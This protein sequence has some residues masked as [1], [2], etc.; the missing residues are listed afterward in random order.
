M[1][2]NLGMKNKY[3]FNFDLKHKRL[4]K[5]SISLGIDY[6]ICCSNFLKKEKG[7]KFL[8]DTTDHKKRSMRGKWNYGYNWEKKVIEKSEIIME[9]HIEKESSVLL[10]YVN[11]N[12]KDHFFILH[13]D[14]DAYWHEMP[15]LGF[16]KYV[17]TFKHKI[18]SFNCNSGKINFFSDKYI[19]DEFKN[20]KLVY[21]FKVNK[22]KYSF[23]SMNI[24]NESFKKDY[25]Y[26]NTVGALLVKD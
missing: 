4:K 19:E 20:K 14:D 13:G 5:F 25:P 21:E 1:G 11:L 8:K 10:G 6:F 12:K 23:Y 18:H 16:F 2:L 24:E 15:P 7:L 3:N 9:T 22:G 26:S 17:T